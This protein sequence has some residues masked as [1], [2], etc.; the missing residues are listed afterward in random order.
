MTTDPSL[1]I[2]ANHELWISD[3]ETVRTWSAEHRKGTQR[4]VRRRVA[5]PR[6]SRLSGQLDGLPAADRA[7]GRD[8]CP[9]RSSTRPGL[10][11]NVLATGRSWVSGTVDV[12]GREA[13]AVECD[14]PRS[15][16]IAADRPDHHL[17]VSFDRDTGVIL[18]L[19]ETIAGDVTRDALVT[20]LLPDAALSPAAFAFSFPSGATLIYCAT[21]ETCPA[22]RGPLFADPLRAYSPADRAEP[23]CQR[24]DPENQAKAARDGPD[25]RRASRGRKEASEQASI[26]SNRRR[27]VEGPPLQ[28]S[29]ATRGGSRLHPARARLR[30]RRPRPNVRASAEGSNRR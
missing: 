2:A 8:R 16:G 10:C 19:V 23:A 4:A 28:V 14:H 17:Q 12:N 13:I 7:A 30:D 24:T 6:R 22:G 11:Q 20:S 27:Q 1:G 26:P 18:R 5:R 21:D 29:S 15:I 9:M 25:R 3:G